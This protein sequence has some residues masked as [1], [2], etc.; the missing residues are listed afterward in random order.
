MNNFQIHLGKNYI[1]PYPLFQYFFR[2]IVGCTFRRTF[3]QQVKNLVFPRATII[4]SLVVKITL[5]LF[6]FY[7][8]SLNGLV[9]LVFVPIMKAQKP[10][11]DCKLVARISTGGR[12]TWELKKRLRRPQWKRCETIGFNEKTEALDVQIQGVFFIF[13]LLERRSHL[14]CY[15]IVRP[16][17]TSLTNWNNREVVQIT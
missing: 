4:D 14:F 12:F 11:F 1:Y 7:E 10:T 13:Y 5:P 17:C 8:E 2:E 9:G 6:G 16:H 15:W 3:N